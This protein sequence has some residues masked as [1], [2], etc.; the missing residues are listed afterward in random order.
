MTKQDII[1]RIKRLRNLA[2]NAAA[3]IHEAATAAKLA[4]ELLQKHEIE[5]AEIEFS[6]GSNESPEE[7]PTPITDWGQKQAVWENILATALCKAYNCQGVM[8]VIDD[9]TKRKTGFYV[10][11]RPSDTQV[12]KYQ[13]AF[14]VAEITRLAHKI[15]PKSM[16]KGEG[17][18]WHHSFRRGAVHAICEALKEAKKEVQA[19]ASSNALVVL[20]KH[21]DEA[22]DLKM[23]LYP[24]SRTVNFSS[25]NLDVNAYR[26]GIEAGKGIQQHTQI[27]SGVKGLLK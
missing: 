27:G 17:K 22:L 5:E 3:S 12:V 15:A 14:F 1:E 20:N 10:I 2:E 4:E 9:G 16:S 26:K 7:D 18:T 21:R 11:G 19:T 8:K 24:R 23:R 6:T 13:M 25:N